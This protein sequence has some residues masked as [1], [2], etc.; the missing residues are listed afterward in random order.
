MADGDYKP[1]RDE[2]GRILPGQ[3]PPNRKPKPW[4]LSALLRE[5]LGQPVPGD[6]DGRT[7]AETLVGNLLDL[8]VG[9]DRE[10]VRAIGTILDRV[11]GKAMQRLEHDVVHTKR[12]VQ[13]DRLPGGAQ[14]RALEVDVD[15]EGRLVYDSGDAQ[16]AGPTVVEDGEGITQQPGPRSPTRE[17]S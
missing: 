8:A 16:G 7:Y 1:E 12:L 4:Q 5:R 11:E 17:D 15:S 10:A 9:G 14:E 6:P 2:R 3:R 13:G